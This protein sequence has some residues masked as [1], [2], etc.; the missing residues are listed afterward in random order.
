MRFRQD[1][2]CFWL[3]VGKIWRLRHKMRFCQ[4]S[5]G[6]FRKMIGCGTYRTFRRCVQSSNNSQQFFCW[7]TTCRGH[8]RRYKTC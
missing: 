8:K 7:K 5:D 3:K 2:S 4:K 6:H 1:S